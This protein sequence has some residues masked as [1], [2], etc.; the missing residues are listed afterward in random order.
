VFAGGATGRE[1]G[2]FTAEKGDGTRD[3]DTAAAGFENRRAAAEFSFGY[4]CG[5][6]V[7]LS[8]EGASVSV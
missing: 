2:R 1:N 3:V 6:S 4:I 8:S 5:V 7:A